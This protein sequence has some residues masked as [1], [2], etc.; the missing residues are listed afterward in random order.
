M[1]LSRR[2]WLKSAGILSGTTL[3]TGAQAS[4]LLTAKEVKEFN[5]RKLS[6]PIRL[7]SNE[8][9]YGPSEKMRKAMVD[10]FDLGCRYPWAYNAD[11]REKIAQ[12]EG[13][14]SDHIVLVAGSTEGLKITGITYA[15]PGDEIISGLPTFLSLMNYAETWGASINWVPL[16]KEY[17]YDLEEIEKRISSKTKL[18]FLCNP[19]NPTGKLLPAKNVMDFCES[20]S[21]KTM[22]FS[23][24]AYYDYIE[25]PTYPSM[26][27][28]VK[29]GKNVIVSKTLSKVY[30]LAG[31][32]LG[33]LV[34]RP[35][36]AEKLSERI[37][38]NTNMMAIEAGKAALEDESFYKFSLDKNLECRK[39]I[40]NTLD[41]LSLR[42]LPSQANFVFFHAK[43]DVS[44]LANE[45]LKKG[46]IIGRPFPPL[47]EWCRIS[48]GTVEEVQLFNQAAIEIFG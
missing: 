36:I 11:L 34:A 30:G 10:S 27:E 7:G 31:I 13:V 6:V 48:T 40:E 2:Q 28:L 43:R 25:D 42:Y 8:N 17:D 14:P 20:V 39:M 19:N 15:G 45:F 21:N 9:P 12:K 46:I 47:D 33:Y 29:K 16:N 38:A 26:V 18:V 44:A 3:L 37:V 22:L 5:P 41:Q 32:R 4:H 1:K 35:D 23:D 24:E